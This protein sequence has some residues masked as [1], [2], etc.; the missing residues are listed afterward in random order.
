MAYLLRVA[1]LPSC[2]FFS[3]IFLEKYFFVEGKRRKFFQDSSSTPCAGTFHL[4]VVAF[5]FASSRAN[6]RLYSHKA[7]NVE[8]EWHRH[9]TRKN[10]YVVYIWSSKEERTTRKGLPCWPEE[11]DWESSMSAYL[12]SL[13]GV[14]GFRR[15]FYFV[16]VSVICIGNERNFL[17]WNSTTFNA[18]CFWFMDLDSKK[19]MPLQLRTQPHPAQLCV[20]P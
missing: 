12:Y 18:T 13:I 15:R 5:D 19:K 7:S 8:L 11:F 14:G 16:G 4:L 17:I 2:I 10:K 3:L 9:W 6:S 1:H 20:H